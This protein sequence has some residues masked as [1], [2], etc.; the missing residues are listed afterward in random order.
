MIVL[1]SLLDNDFYKF[2]MQQGV[3][4]L[5]PRAKARY[6]FINR[7]KHAFPQGFA[8]ALKESVN[9]MAALRLTAD[10]KS[11]LC[12]TCPY[13]DPVYLDF[14]QGYIYDPSEV[15]ILQ[16]G[17]DVEVTLEGFWYRTI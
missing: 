15:S 6:H 9:N 12:K 1:A 14:L 11:W 7:G 2:T 10:E 16:K 5:F 17:E 8:E 4:K 13:L 3:V